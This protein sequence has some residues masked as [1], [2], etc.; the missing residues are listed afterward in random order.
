MNFN[1]LSP[2]LS[3]SEHIIRRST[4]Y[5]PIMK[6]M[7]D[8]NSTKFLRDITAALTLT[9]ILIPQVISYT[10]TLAKIPTVV[11]LKS[12]IFPLFIYAIFGSSHSLSIGLD[13]VVCILIGQYKHENSIAFICGIITLLLGLMR[14]GFLDAI[15][16]RPIIAG[17]ISGVACTIIIEQIPFMFGIHV[18]RGSSPLE[19]LWSEIETLDTLHIQTLLLS[20]F[21]LIFII[22]YNSFSKILK[23]KV[24][25]I[26]PLVILNIFF[27]YLLNFKTY[28]I[29]IVGNIEVHG[30]LFK[31]SLPLKNLDTS[32]KSL[33][34]PSGVIA[35]IG[36]MES[37]IA[38][39]SFASIKGYAISRNRE[40]VALGLTN[41][42]G[43]FFGCMPVYG[44]L[45]RSMI[46]HNSHV[47]TPISQIFVALFVLTSTLLLLPAFKYLPLAATACIVTQAAYNLI[48]RQKISF[49]IKLHAWK[50]IVISIVV[51]I[52]TLSISIEYG[53]LFAILIALLLNV[54]NTTLPKITLLG[55]RHGT[56][57][58]YLALSEF[59]DESEGIDGVLLLQI[60]ESLHFANSAEMMERVHRLEA[61]GHLEHHPSD[62]PSQAAIHHIIFDIG[63]MK[64]VDSTYI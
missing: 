55:R 23:F 53:A 8:Y 28:G 1:S 27:S 37:M 32:V 19:L 50:D 54:R 11:G 17:F 61:H 10:M 59:P 31:M 34:G 56:S 45:A 20:C 9:C 62:H 24:P 44:S 33:I 52:I 25:V 46:S 2:L 63:N 7:Q 5:V 58:E 29:A 48:E 6:W 47:E 3:S 40:L 64:R 15:F 43:S 38:S 35:V 41:I 42:V 49:L 26:L 14:F 13:A 57:D 36:F 18:A 4:Y 21:C 12:T 16:S 22:L 39:K 51:F 60:D 30:D